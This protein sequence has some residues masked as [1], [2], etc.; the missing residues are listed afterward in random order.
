MGIAQ[1]RIRAGF[2]G[3][4][5]AG[6]AAG[7]ALSLLLLGGCSQLGEA[8][9][10]FAEAMKPEISGQAETSGRG[11]GDDAAAPTGPGENEAP[12]TEAPGAVEAQPGAAGTGTGTSETG[13]PGAAEAPLREIPAEIP[14]NGTPAP[15]PDAPESSGKPLPPTEPLERPEP[16][17][18][19]QTPAAPAPATPEPGI[20]AP[21]PDPVQVPAAQNPAEIPAPGPQLP[22]VFQYHRPGDLL[23]NSGTGSPS[24]MNFAPDMR[25]P[26]ATH[27]TYMGS[28]VY[29]PGGG[30]GPKDKPDQC[31]ASNFAYPWR[32]NFCEKRTRDTTNP[33]CPAKG[34]HLGQDIRAGDPGLCR[35]ILRT[36]RAERKEIPVVAVED[37]IISNIGSYTVTLR[38]DR[39]TYRYLHLNMAAL[40]VKNNQDVKAGDLIGFL[41]NDFGVDKAGKPVPTTLHLHF[42]IRANTESFGW[43]TAPPYPALVA[44]YERRE[45]GRGEAVEA[46]AGAAGN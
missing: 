37:G 9:E 22:I 29:R 7:L 35:K 27:A 4:S 3:H 18:E 44:A 13:T 25:F 31:D 14:G 10:L 8:G 6:M 23:P 40:A 17:P 19:P 1:A 26:I 42:E 11:S 33:F 2:Q 39:N 34:V 46:K 5:R 15:A 43:A 12:A 21:G 16:A 20:P 32:D 24:A 38:T 45:K 30:L 41:S 28:Q 36:P